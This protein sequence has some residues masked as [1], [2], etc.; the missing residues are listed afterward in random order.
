M[1]GVL[2]LLLIV[3]ILVGLGVLLWMEQRD[4]APPLESEDAQKAAIELRAI[5]RRLDVA[6]TKAEVRADH[7]RLRRAIDHALKDDDQR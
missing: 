5:R 2:V 6:W 1:I 7:A 3:A 4:Q